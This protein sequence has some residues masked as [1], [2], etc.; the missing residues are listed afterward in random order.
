[1]FTASNREDQGVKPQQK[2]D[3]FSL[4]YLYMPDKYNQNKANKHSLTVTLPPVAQQSASWFMLLHIS[5]TLHF[6]GCTADHMTSKHFQL[7]LMAAN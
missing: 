6:P 2:C 3:S 7:K 1:M 5:K 4:N